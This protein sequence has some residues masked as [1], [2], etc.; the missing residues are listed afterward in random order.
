MS[1]EPAKPAVRM[2]RVCGFVRDT[3]VRAYQSAHSA[4]GGS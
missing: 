3:P 4:K 1:S 2:R